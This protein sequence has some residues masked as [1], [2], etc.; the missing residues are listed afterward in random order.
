MSTPIEAAIL[1]LL[2]D[3]VLTPWFDRHDLAI[4][5]LDAL[6]DDIQLGDV[7]AVITSLLASGRIVERVNRAGSVEVALAAG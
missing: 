4:I 3:D 2:R 7:E 6:G 5:A 1:T